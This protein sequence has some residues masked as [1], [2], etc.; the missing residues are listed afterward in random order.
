[1]SAGPNFPRYRSPGE[2]AFAR[3]GI[4][5][6]SQRREADPRLLRWVHCRLVDRHQCRARQRDRDLSA[7]DVEQQTHAAI[8]V[9]AL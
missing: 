3:F 8:A 7:H 5:Q 1:M 6:I 2:A 9:E 4:L